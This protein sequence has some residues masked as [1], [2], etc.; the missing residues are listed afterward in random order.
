MQNLE[1]KEPTFKI[2]KEDNMN[3][4]GILRASQLLSFATDDTDSIHQSTV[5]P[6]Q[7]ILDRF[8]HDCMIDLQRVSN[9]QRKQ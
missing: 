7:M 8:I 2:M 9:T 5:E 1:N 4:T 3:G 6:D